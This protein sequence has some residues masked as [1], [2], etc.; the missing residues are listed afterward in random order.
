M[1][2]TDPHTELPRDL[3]AP[4][5]VLP[6]PD[7]DAVP[8]LGPRDYSRLKALAHSAPRSGTLGEGALAEWLSRCR[9]VPQ[10]DLSPAVAVLGARVTFAAEGEAWQSRILVLPEEHAADDRTLSVL[11]P[12]GM[13]LL[14]AE[15]GQWVEATGPDGRAQA[16]RLLLVDQHPA[17]VFSTEQRNAPMT[18]GREAALRPPLLMSDEGYAHLVALAEVS[19]RK[20]PLVARLLLEEAD[21]AE[22]VPE[23]ELPA[24]VV[25]LGS[26]VEFSDSATGAT[27][28]VQLVLPGGADLAEGRISVLSLVGA[29]LIGLSAGQA[30]DWPTQDGR[31]RRLSVLQV[32]PPPDVDGRK[33]G[34][35][36][37]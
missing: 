33:A 4:S 26:Q 19:Q 8:V 22:L 31:L 35:L 28:Q 25:T 17:A 11:T 30:I 6:A 37:S 3:P 2:I 12:Q 9:V 10:D 27:R 21:R 7:P 15:A 23:G 20:N 34:A 29:G 5:D 14:G 1:S 13:A 24:A 36:V 16:L 32:Q 18:D